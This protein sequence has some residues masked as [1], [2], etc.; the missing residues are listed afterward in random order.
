MKNHDR[1]GEVTKKLR[2]E[3]RKDHIRRKKKYESIDEKKADDIHRKRR[4]LLRARKLNFYEY[5]FLN[6]PGPILTHPNHGF[7]CSSRYL[8]PDEIKRARADLPDLPGYVATLSM[9][10]ELRALITGGFT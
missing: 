9:F 2:F 4:P 1:L 10:E 8:N 7:K 6:R 5:I 3:G